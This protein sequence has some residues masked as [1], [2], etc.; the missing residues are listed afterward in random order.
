MD[1]INILEE[2]K[3]LKKENELEYMDV[4]CLCDY[5]DTMYLYDV[6]SEIADNHISIYTYDLYN[7][8][9]EDYNNSDWVNQYKQECG[10]CDEIDAEIRGGQYL[11]YYND[12][13]NNVDDLL[14]YYYYD[15]LIKNDI[16]ELTENQYYNLTDFISYHNDTIESLETLKNEVLDDEQNI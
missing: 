15:L 4:D 12:L 9:N 5:S 8:L 11:C 14:L 13:C 2:L 16:N 7:W 3:T 10:S 1:K 6:I